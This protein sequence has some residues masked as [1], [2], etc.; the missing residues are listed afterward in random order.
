M[1]LT[2]ETGQGHLHVGGERLCD[3]DLRCPGAGMPVSLLP[4]AQAS[5]PPGCVVGQGQV[6]SK[7]SRLIWLTC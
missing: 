4:T 1:A 6:D 3:P 7:A 5:L 2:R